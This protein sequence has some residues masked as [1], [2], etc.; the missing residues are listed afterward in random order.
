MASSERKLGV[1]ICGLGRAGSIHL[2]NVAKSFD[3]Q[4]LYVVEFRTEHAQ[5]LLTKY[6]Q[7]QCEIVSPSD[8]DKML[9]DERVDFV[10]V[11]TPTNLHEEQVLKSLNAGKGVF[12]E[13]PIAATEEAT[14]NCYKAAE[15]NGKPLFCSF[16]R[17]YDP[18]L[19]KL[20]N[21]RSELGQIQMVKMCARD[22]PFPPIEYLKISGGVFH[23]CLVHDIDAACWI[24][25]EFPKRVYA[26]AHAHND[27]IKE[28]GDVDTVAAILKFESGALAIIDTSRDSRYGYDQ[29]CEVFGTNGMFLN[30]NQRPSNM[31]KE[32]LNGQSMGRMYNSFADR[33]ELSYIQALQHFCRAVKGEESI[34]ISKESTINVSKIATALEESCKKGCEIEVPY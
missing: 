32:E 31:I 12:C 17:R 11:C 8:L 6:H 19:R 34:E 18:S 16:N 25:G 33:Y 24:L 20:Y 1:G 27:A 10:M 5:T 15:S 22:S 2:D 28:M 13:K 14:L 21:E 26:A 4:L 7:D 23:D 3:L 29:R 30:Q 9:S